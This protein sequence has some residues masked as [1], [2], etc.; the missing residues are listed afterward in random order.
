MDASARGVSAWSCACAYCWWA[1]TGAGPRPECGELAPWSPGPGVLESVFLFAWVCRFPC[2]NCPSQNSL[3]QGVPDLAMCQ[4]CCIA[5]T[6]KRFSN[7]KY[8]EIDTEVFFSIT[9][10]WFYPFLL[11]S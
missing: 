10:A 1:G 2:P 5:N 6:V 11:F 3:I 7:E 4:N 9:S 8:E